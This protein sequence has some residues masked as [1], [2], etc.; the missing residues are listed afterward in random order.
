MPTPFQAAFCRGQPRCGSQ[1]PQVARGGH[2]PE[3]VFGTFP[4]DQS[5]RRVLARADAQGVRRAAGGWTDRWTVDLDRESKMSSFQKCLNTA[6]R[7]DNVA[8][9]RECS[10][11]TGDGPRHHRPA[12]R[13]PGVLPAHGGW[14]LQHHAHGRRDR[15]LPAHGGWPQRPADQP[16]RRQVLPAHAG[17]APLIARGSARSPRAPAHAGMVPPSPSASPT[18]TSAPRARA[19]GPQPTSAVRPMPPCSPRTRGM[20]PLPGHR[21]L[22]VSRAP[23]A[24]GDGATTTSPPS[25]LR[26]RRL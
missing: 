8:G 6:L 13:R 17:T 22:T 18:R 20:V 25:S 14:P 26:R 4:W 12:R 15:V 23:R 9:Q 21:A 19:D 7:G 11:R 2:L 16:R 10:P 5:D 3:S 1:D 24:R